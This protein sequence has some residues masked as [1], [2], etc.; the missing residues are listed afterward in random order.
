MNRAKHTEH[1]AELYGP[2]ASSCCCV[3]GINS[4]APL[5]LDL[6]IPI[7]IIALEGISEGQAAFWSCLS[8]YSEEER[9]GFVTEELEPFVRVAL[10]PK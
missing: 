9:W 5:H 6:Q 3:T 10:G 7:T 1:K 4:K 2:S 8:C